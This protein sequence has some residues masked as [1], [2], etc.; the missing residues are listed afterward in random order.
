MSFFLSERSRRKLSLVH[1]DL[2]LLAEA[3]IKVTQVDFAVTEGLRT[4]QRQEELLKARATTT[5][6]S[7]H[8]TGHAI[9][10]AAIVNGKADWHP[11][12]YFH[13]AD[14][15]LSEAAKLQIKICWGGNWRTFRDYCHIELDRKFY[16]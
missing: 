14:A 12:L 7:R 4:L 13:I 2:T 1:K 11:A 8:L 10:I 5:M 6:A 15:F 16:P 3:A 9:D